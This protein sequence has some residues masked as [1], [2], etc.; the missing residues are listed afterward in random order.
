MRIDEILIDAHLNP[1]SEGLDLVTVAEYTEQMSNGNK[2]PAIDVF[3]DGICY[4][5]VDGFHRIEAAKQ[6]SIDEIE[7]NLYEG[8]WRDAKLHSFC[9]N[10][11]HGK[12]RTNAD[13]RKAVTEILQDEE[14]S[15]WSDREIAKRCQV[16]QP[17]VSNLRH[18]LLTDNIISEKP[19]ERTYQTKHGTTSTMHTDNI[20]KKAQR[21]E[22]KQPPQQTE[23]PHAQHERQNKIIVTR[24]ERFGMILRIMER[25]PEDIISFVYRDLAVQYHPDKQHGVD[26]EI[27]KSR[28]EAFAFISDVRDMWEVNDADFRTLARVKGIIETESA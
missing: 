23:F 13:K 5:V 24:W 14:W 18:E 8:N 19:A 15:K 9:V 4:W 11:E 2:F 1:R 22:P 20:G 27:A 26:A 16:S 6:A 12:R 17:F 25:V 3:S 7:V 10:A 21:P 28:A